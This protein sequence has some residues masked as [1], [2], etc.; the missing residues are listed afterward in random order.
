MSSTATTYVRSAH[1]SLPSLKSRLPASLYFAASAVAKLVV[2]QASSI[3]VGSMR[4]TAS[5]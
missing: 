1:A 4:P 3:A 5:S 2:E